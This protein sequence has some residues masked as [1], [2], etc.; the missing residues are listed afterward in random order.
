MDRQWIYLL[1]FFYVLLALPV[2]ISAE[3]GAR[4]DVLL[5]FSTLYLVAWTLIVVWWYGE[6]IASSLR[7]EKSPGTAPDKGEAGAAGA[8]SDKAQRLSMETPR[9]VRIALDEAAKKLAN[10]GIGTPSGTAAPAAKSP[11]PSPASNP[12]F[13]PK[14]PGPATTNAAESRPLLVADAPAAI[15]ELV[16]RA[17]T[18]MQAPEDGDACVKRLPAGRVRVIVSALIPSEGPKQAV[19]SRRKQFRQ[20]LDERLAS[21][22]W[23]QATGSAVYTYRH[24][25]T[26]Q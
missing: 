25:L 10:L 4:L 16:E 9:L 13:Q 17:V 21:I 24:K 23:H 20:Q 7:S 3:S 6:H 8:A 26:S 19:A 11:A 5:D 1:A 12:P 2:V 22:G 15:G 18:A 14:A